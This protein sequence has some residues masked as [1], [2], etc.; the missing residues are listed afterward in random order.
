MS[1][2]VARI[3]LYPLDWD[4]HTLY[5]RGGLRFQPALHA[6]LAHGVTRELGPLC[7]TLAQR[8]FQVF[9]PEFA[10]GLADAL[11]LMAAP[12]AVQALPQS[13]LLEGFQRELDTLLAAAHHSLSLSLESRLTGQP[14][15]GQPYEQL[16]A[17]GRD[18]Y[19]QG[20]HLQPESD[21][22]GQVVVVLD[23]LRLSGAKEA[24]LT[25]ACTKLGAKALVFCTLA[26]APKALRAQAPELGRSLRRWGA[27]SPGALLKLLG[28]DP[29]MV[30][31]WL[32]QRLAHDFLASEWQQMIRQMPPHLLTALVSYLQQHPPV[33]SGARRNLQLVLEAAL[34]QHRQAN[35]TRTPRGRKK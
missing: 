34:Q 11:L 31:E 8:F 27:Q 12:P 29:V 13:L 10:N 26:A 25:E 17:D 2:T 33:G 18:H 4:G 9:Q 22:Q 3:T 21:L 6:R 5:G 19:W 35:L 15:T 16:D 24:F 20:L 7:R 14:G 23:Y 32:V 30:S 1:P 28:P